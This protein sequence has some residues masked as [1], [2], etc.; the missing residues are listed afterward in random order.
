MGFLEGL[1]VPG[2]MILDGLQDMV[3]L[4][5]DRIARC[6]VSGRIASSRKYGP[7]WFGPGYGQ[8]DKGLDSEMSGFWKDGRKV[9]HSIGI[10]RFRLVP[11][12]FGHCL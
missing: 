2:N 6:E 5:K 9:E 3:S 8:F 10:P 1:P 11:F 4:I 7:G 12:I